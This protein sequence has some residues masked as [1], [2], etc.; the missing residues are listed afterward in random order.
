MIKRKLH[1][2]LMIQ[3]EFYFAMLKTIFYKQVQRE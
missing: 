1:G 2:G 3:Y